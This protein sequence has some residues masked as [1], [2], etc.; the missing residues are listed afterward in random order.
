MINNKMLFLEAVVIKLHRYSALFMHKQLPVHKIL[1][2]LSF[3]SKREP[4]V[5]ATSNYVIL[6]V[7]VWAST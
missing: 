2:T 1:G 7:L 5:Q 3:Y 6:I 4:E